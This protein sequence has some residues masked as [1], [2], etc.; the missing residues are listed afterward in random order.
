MR[1]HGQV[2]PI[3]G[4]EPS[5]ALRGAVGVEGV[6]LGGLTLVVNVPERG[7]AAGDDPLLSLGATEL[8]QTC[9]GARL[10]ER[11]ILNTAAA[12]GTR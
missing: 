7:Q 4:A 8:H 12:Y 3:L 5:N 11:S 10:Q 9:E 6:L 2:S 1:H